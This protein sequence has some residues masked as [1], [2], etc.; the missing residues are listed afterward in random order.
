MRI[1]ALVTIGM[2]VLL[3]SCRKYDVDIASLNTSAFDPDGNGQSLLRI[4][5]I[6]TVALV[7]GAVHQQ[8][9]HCTLDPLL[10]AA[11]DFVVRYVESS[12]PDTVVLAPSAVQQGRITIHNQQVQLGTEYCF[13]LDIL[14]EGGTIDQHRIDTCAVAQL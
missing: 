7:S 12:I 10:L 13:K 14:I 9:I 1:I 11:D 2:L 5:S 3:C 8:R 6:R 4:D